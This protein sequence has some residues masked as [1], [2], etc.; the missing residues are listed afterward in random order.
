MAR[1]TPRREREPRFTIAYRPPQPGGTG[2]VEPGEA[3]DAP[4]QTRAP[5]GRPPAQPARSHDEGITRNET[6]PTR[7]CDGP[8][9]RTNARGGGFGLPPVRSVRPVPGYP[10]CPAEVRRQV[11][12]TFRCTTCRASRTAEPT[13]SLVPVQAVHRGLPMGRR[14]RPRQDPPPA[15]SFDVPTSPGRF[16]RGKGQGD[17]PTTPDRE[18]RG[19]GGGNPARRRTRETGRR[20]ANPAWKKTRAPDKARVKTPARVGAPS[21]GRERL[22]EPPSGDS[23]EEPGK[24]T[25]TKRGEAQGSCADPKVARPEGTR[26]PDRGEKP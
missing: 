12:E 6:V 7:R 23:R 17:P 2:S 10:P 22:R 25:L 11:L 8:R 4:P 1:V 13:R 26:E 19:T 3:G 16:R 24:T 14:R 15:S 9:V 21:P 5:A 20:E 18:A